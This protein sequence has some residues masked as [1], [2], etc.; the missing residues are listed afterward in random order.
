VLPP[1]PSEH[2]YRKA[3]AGDDGKCVQEGERTLELILVNSQAANSQLP[4]ALRWE[5]SGSWR[6]GI[7]SCGGLDHA[8]LEG[9]RL[10][11][12]LDAVLLVARGACATN[13]LGRREGGLLIDGRR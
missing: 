8:R 9:V 12:V 11:L 4:N 5:F 10:V 2:E 7:G 6:L 3:D 1:K 13:F